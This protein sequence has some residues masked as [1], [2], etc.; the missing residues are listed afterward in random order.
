MSYR[1]PGRLFSFFKIF[2][3][4]CW[5][6][7]L[8]VRSYPGRMS[9]L[10]SFHFV[11]GGIIC[12]RGGGG[13]GGVMWCKSQ[14]VIFKGNVM[15]GTLRTPPTSSDRPKVRCKIRLQCDDLWG[16]T[17][18]QNCDLRMG[19][20]GLQWEDFEE[21]PLMKIDVRMLEWAAMLWLL[22]NYPPP[23]PHNWRKWV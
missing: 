14:M 18:E 11:V 15:G 5:S 19:Y 2:L 21:P 8:T 16:F 10:K 9:S 13:G 6:M 20:N 23:P 1:T 4:A 12:L 17:A 22:R 7:G 3:S